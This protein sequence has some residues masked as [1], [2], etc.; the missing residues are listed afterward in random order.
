[1]TDSRTFPKAEW[2]S[3]RPAEV[4]MDA[5]KLGQVQQWF[6]D[7]LG[8]KGGRLV[9]VRGGRVVLELYHQMSRSIPTCWGSS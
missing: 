3:A 5:E 6:A 2:E 8:D 1:M 4:G 7:A 9:I